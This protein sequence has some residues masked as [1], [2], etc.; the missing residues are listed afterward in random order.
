MSLPSLPLLLPVDSVATD[1]VMVDLEIYRKRIGTFNSSKS[2]FRG[3]YT[4]EFSQ[5]SGNAFCMSSFVSVVNLSF[6]LLYL[7]FVTM[8]AAL[9]MSMSISLPVNNKPIN[10]SRYSF[11][12]KNE[13]YNLSIG[14]A[15]VKY[16]FI[17]IISIIFNE[18]ISN[19][20][21]KRYV[22]Y[23]LSIK[24][25]KSH[26]LH[27]GRINK[28]FQSLIFWLCILNFLL[29]TIVNP[30]LLNPG[31]GRTGNNVQT[32]PLKIL[33][34]NVQGLV[35]PR[36]LGS[37]SPPLN[38]T[39]LYEFQSFIFKQRPDIVV[40]NESWLKSSILNSEILPENNYKIIRCDRSAKTHPW[41]P[42]QPKK[43]RKHGGGVFIAHRKDIGIESTEVSI[44]KVQ[45]EI[46]TIN[47]KL[48]T[49]KRFSLSTFY[50]VGTL[51][52]ENFD[53]VKSYLT[54]LANKKKLD[55]HLLVGDLNFPE[56]AWPDN[57]TTV[58]LHKK[59]TELFMSEL[60][61]SQ[62]ISEPTHK[63]G[64]ILDLLFTN[65]P[66]LV[67]NLKILGQNEAC[68][69]DH[70]GIMFSIKLDVSLKKTV[71]RKVFDY[72]K[73]DWKSL[74]F[75]L[76]RVNWNNYIS[77][78]DPHISWPIFK[79]VLSKLCDKYIPKKSVRYQFQPP[80]FDTDCDK[81]LR[82]K[83]KWRA[84]SYSDSGTEEDLEMFRKYRSKFKKVMTE[85]MRLNVVDE[86]DT[87]LI[88][89][90]FW[91]YVKSKSKSSRI[92]ETIR[93]KTRY[94]TKPV[95]QAKLFN[96]F[97]YE[98]FSDESSYDIDINM[99]G[100]DQFKDLRFHELDVLLLLKNVN[101]S[102]AAGPDGIHGMVLK[103]C[104]A[105]LAK[106]LTSLYNVSFV[107]GCIPDDWKLASV[108]P[109]HKKD[110]KSSVEN[111]RPISL[112]SLVMKV[113]EKCIRK[114]LFSVTEKFLDPRQHG[115]INGKSCTTQMI[116]F[117]YDLALGL[118]NKSKFDIIYF[119]FAKAFDSVS[120][121]LILKKLKQEFG[122]NGLMLRFIKSYLQG[123]Q[124]EVVIGGV[125]SGVLPV[126]SGVPQGSILG[127]LLFVIFINDMFNCISDGTNIALYADDTK[128]WR[129]II[130]SEDHFVLQG[131]IDKLNHWS[132]ANK[133]K[134]HPSKCKALSVTNQHNILHNLPFTIFN[135]K[136]GSVFIDYVQLQVDLGVTI[137]NKLLW[138]NHCD[139]L[140]KNANSKL[141]LL[142][143]TCHFATNKKQKRAF[144]L[145]VVRS[146][147]EHCSV[148]WHPDSSNQMSKFNAIQ[149]KAVK[150]I[151]GQQFSHYTD[152]EYSSKL[153]ELS[154]LPIKSKFALNDLIMFYKI[155]N[156]IVPISLPEHFTVIKPKD[157]RF[158][159]KTVAIIDNKDVTSIKCSIKPSCDSFRK[160][161]FYRTMTLWNSIPYS[162]RQQSTITKFKSQVT[163]FL[164]SADLDWPD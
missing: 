107:T 99:N 95:D 76:K 16:L 24:Q 142:M 125:K 89:K 111:Y 135:Y 66:D 138:S 136:L 146:I 88:S 86:S 11:K 129:R 80:W 100:D 8:V 126:K 112:T 92:P 62:M 110:D 46:L 1:M 164:L 31:P 19:I 105:S 61:H 49:G 18:S 149:K 23:R 90:K 139:K 13:F 98:Q 158:T 4:K 101:P 113:F 140:A 32:R 153:K 40:V 122:I 131:D 116:P 97:F 162:I 137:T 148:I 117:T 50:R 85:K 14:L 154:I 145:T 39:K 163:E 63:N 56:I 156:C 68:S 143:R 141:A 28:L 84:K 37:E 127:P 103:N 33:Y 118:N 47:F 17:I 38:M 70:F 25:A 152:M 77:T 155:L 59:F 115:F 42:S 65:V 5:S 121:D 159:R 20:H 58:D 78:N 119:D 55:K 128:I 134:F 44:V 21:V 64:N 132:L 51:G 124:Q 67:D 30:N 106:P 36:D 150:W 75:E 34:K 96:E 22:L 52:I 79:E 120:H 144:Y 108:V 157:V 130:Y 102:K 26:R 12:L 57:S 93:L 133:M 71:K 114:E 60:D 53:L 9:I 73:A 7:Y 27:I 83:E 109:I 6:C 10:I 48:P 2:N 45:A 54:T 82:E 123:R 104:A 81:I 69:S 87:S 35:N 147:F 41:D 74:N 3:K 94:R 15:H 72:S 43:F 29:I 151:Y 160:C 161:F 91:K